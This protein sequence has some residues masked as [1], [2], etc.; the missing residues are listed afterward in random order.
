MGETA[1]MAAAW[2][3]RVF[4]EAALDE[5]EQGDDRPGGG[6]R[7]FYGTAAAAKAAADIRRGGDVPRCGVC[8]RRG[9]AARELIVGPDPYQSE[10]NGDYTEVTLCGECYMDSSLEI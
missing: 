5:A 6:Y 8:E 4:G 2:A 3:G 9:S 1:D 10:I 7:L